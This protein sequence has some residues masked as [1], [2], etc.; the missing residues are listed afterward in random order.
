MKKIS[1]FKSL[2]KEELKKVKGGTT[3]F[4]NFDQKINQL[5]DILST[6]LKSMKEMESSVIRNIN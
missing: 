4:E 5:F 2:T 1:N 6:V 3:M